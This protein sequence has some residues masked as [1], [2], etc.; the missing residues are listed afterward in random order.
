MIRQQQGF[1]IVELLVAMAILGIVAVGFLN[2]LTSSSRAVVHADQIDT[3]RV[4]A[5]A[6]M[7][8]VK[9]QSFSS[10]G[11]YASNDAVMT[12]YPGYTVAITAA[13]AAQ[14]DSSIQVVTVT[15]SQ[16]GKVVTQL[17]DCKAK[18]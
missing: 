16:G 1:S 2:A 5:E 17:Q 7:E 12:Q 3:G 4:I 15:V 18:R 9:N 13:T 6:Q 14:R 10:A 8:W 11:N